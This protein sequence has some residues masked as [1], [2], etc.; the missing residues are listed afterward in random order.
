MR[1]Q[2]KRMDEILY[3][4]R[5]ELARARLAE[6]RRLKAVV[7]GYDE[8]ALARPHAYRSTS[9]APHEQAV[10]DIL[11]H[12][13]NHQQHH[14]GQAHACLSIAT[15]TEP[16]GLDLL[17]MQRGPAGARLGR[18]SGRLM[19]SAP[20]R[21]ADAASGLEVVTIRIGRQGSHEMTDRRGPIEAKAFIHLDLD[22]PEPGH[23][24]LQY[25]EPNGPRPEVVSASLRAPLGLDVGFRLHQFDAVTER[26]IHVEMGVA[27]SMRLVV[28]DTKACLR[29]CSGISAD[30]NLGLVR[31]SPLPVRS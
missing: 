26:I 14:R 31:Q 16:P 28:D 18:A 25:E 19:R 24:P 2:P 5:L 4:D 1:K 12:L 11:H 15:K 9:G 29:V 27:G 30:L 21:I 8:G 10:S 23:V 20:V 7:D 3:E 6:D 17:L 22:C 13:F